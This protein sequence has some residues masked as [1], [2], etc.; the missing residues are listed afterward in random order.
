MERK[1]LIA[2]DGEKSITL[3]RNGTTQN[4][5]NS[6]NRSSV[7]LQLNYGKNNFVYSAEKGE[8]NLEVT[9][10]HTDLFEGV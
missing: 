9:M 3:R 8:N 1:F 5:I 6:V 4:I 2:D 10:T 7:W